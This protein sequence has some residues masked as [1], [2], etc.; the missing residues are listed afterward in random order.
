LPSSNCRLLASAIT[1]AGALAGVTACGP[2]ADG[3]ADAPTTIARRG[4][5]VSPPDP[6]GTPLPPA[7][8]VPPRVGVNPSVRV[9][10][11]PPRVGL[12]GAVV[13]Q[14]APPE[15]SLPKS[16]A[17]TGAPGVL[18]AEQA[19]ICNTRPADTTPSEIAFPGRFDLPPDEGLDQATVFLAGWRLK[20][21]N[22]DH[23]VARV[24][25]SVRDVQLARDV[26]TWRVEGSLADD[27]GDDPYEL[28][29][30]LTVLAWSSRAVDL[31]VSDG[32]GT[33]NH[34]HVDSVGSGGYVSTDRHGGVLGRFR[35][36][37]LVPRGF[38]AE[39]LDGEETAVLQIASI[40]KNEQGPRSGP[41]Q[42]SAFVL[43]ND[44]AARI[45]PFSFDHWVSALGGD[46]ADWIEP[47]FR[48]S[49]PDDIDNCFGV[50]GYTSSGQ[51]IFAGSVEHTD[52][53]VSDLPF[54]FAV[55][56]L[57]SW[58]LYYACDGDQYVLE[59]GISVH[60][61]AYTFDEA[62]QRGTLRYTVTSI[63]RDD[64][65]RPAHFSTDAV[66]ILGLRAPKL[67]ITGARWPST[68][69]GTIAGVPAQEGAVRNLTGHTIHV[70]SAT[71]GG[72]DINE[73]L[74]MLR[75]FPGGVGSGTQPF[76]AFEILAGGGLD[77]A[78]GDLLKVVGNFFPRAHVPASG[79]RDAYLD[80]QTDDAL[81]PVIHVDL[82]GLVPP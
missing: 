34:D 41:W 37:V 15:F 23:P 11:H 8:P 39:L 43:A 38:R 16:R 2:S 6:G 49:F 77:L 13:K 64:D 29:V 71:P 51:P 42:R 60:D 5:V 31:H 18:R 28:C 80:L 61:A 17:I 73:F 4:L 1:L 79:R 30:L 82:T 9:T 35:T 25:V 75:F 40:L 59:T 66:G 52:Y 63:L 44:D 78:A 36:K 10:A 58:D 72:A 50:V 65:D 67:S 19:E 45:P 33:P 3:Q 24:H 74:P 12:P 62:T 48:L 68:A 14:L 21:L 76:F 57:T 26:L 46:D 56:V 54:E 27:N 53:E 69:V 47:S 32:D 22:G 20:F 81:W 55:P 70:R 7:V